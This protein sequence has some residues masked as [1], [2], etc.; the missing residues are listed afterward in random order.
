MRGDER[1]GFGHISEV[2]GRARRAGIEAVGG[3]GWG[4]I[5]EPDTGVVDGRAGLQR[6]AGRR[7]LQ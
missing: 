6:D 5:G 7:W 2:P 3:D 4:A 1:L